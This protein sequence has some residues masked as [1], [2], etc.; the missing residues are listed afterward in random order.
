MEE[1]KEERD[2]EEGRRR[3]REE[4]EKSASSV[5][6][7]AEQ[8]CIPKSEQAGE[9][10]GERGLIGADGI[11]ARAEEIKCAQAPQRL[12]GGGRLAPRCRLG[13]SARGRQRQAV[14]SSKS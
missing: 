1:L 2:D 9:R 11:K 4:I 6:L 14:R 7:S 12:D 10:A 8:N 3:R 13:E 5:T